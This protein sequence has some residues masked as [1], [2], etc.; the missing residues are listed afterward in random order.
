MCRSVLSGIWLCETVLTTE[1]ESWST[2]AE[3]E[4]WDALTRVKSFDVS[5]TRRVNS[6][7]SIAERPQN[8]IETTRATQK[9]W[10]LLRPEFIAIRLYIERPGKLNNPMASD[11]EPKLIPK[12]DSFRAGPRDAN[13]F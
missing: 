6:G 11:P 10:R 5:S 13:A 8:K 4:L 12:S 9:R 2:T 3:D 1:S 7:I